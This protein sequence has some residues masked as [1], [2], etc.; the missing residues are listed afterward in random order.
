LIALETTALELRQEETTLAD[1][2]LYTIHHPTNAEGIR[3]PRLRLYPAGIVMQTTGAE[4]NVLYP[5]Q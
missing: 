2:I 1:Y 4:E 5:K 3:L